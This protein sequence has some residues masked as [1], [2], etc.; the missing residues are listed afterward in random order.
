[1]PLWNAVPP[2]WLSRSSP[3]STSLLDANFFASAALVAIFAGVALT[4]EARAAS[5]TLAYSSDVLSMPDEIRFRT[6]CAPD[7]FNSF[8]NSAGEAL[9]GLSALL[10]LSARMPGLIVTLESF[11]ERCLVLS[12]AIWDRFLPTLAGS[13][14]KAATTLTFDGLSPAIF[15]CQSPT[16]FLP[17]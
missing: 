5:A 1:M 4:N 8:E 3:A 11:E 2:N 17:L 12:V 6:T 7:F 10:L 16:V 9:A 15:W 14:S 13:M